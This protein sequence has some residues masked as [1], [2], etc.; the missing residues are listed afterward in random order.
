VVS[1]SGFQPLTVRVTDS[2][3]P[4][5][6]VLAASVLFQSTVLRPV[7]NDLALAT[8]GSAPAESGMPI[9][10]STTES[11]TLSNSSG[12]ASFTPSVGSFS[13]TLEIE[14]QISAGIAASLQAVMESVPET[15]IG[16]LNPPAGGPNYSDFRCTQMALWD[17]F[18][19]PFRDVLHEQRPDPR[20]EIAAVYTVRKL[21][22]QGNLRQD[23]R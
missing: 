13:G 7:G 16:S 20:R 14:I 17:V 11:T 5:N 18:P 8:G 15:Y 3:T 23:D 22:E 2:S 21:H 10:L 6:P 1:G 9:I 4:P 19:E 12:L